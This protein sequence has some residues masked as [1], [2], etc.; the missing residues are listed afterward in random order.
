M[1]LSDG[2]IGQMMEKVVL[3][4]QKPRRTEEEIRKECPW[5]SMGHTPDRNPN[6]ITS[7]ELKPE[8]MEER[9]LHLQEKY[10]QIVRMRY[11]LR[12]SSVKMQI[13]LSLVS[14][15]LH[16]SARRLLS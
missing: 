6:I 14:V 16:V 13:I 3:P 7:L 2:V 15:V 1:I 10:R 5:A 9:N 11:A 8:I 12:P 4:P